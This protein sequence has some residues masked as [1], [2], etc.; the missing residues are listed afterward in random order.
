ML[1]LVLPVPMPQQ[2]QA[3]ASSRAHIEAG[4]ELAGATLLSWPA[5]AVAGAGATLLR[6]AKKHGRQQPQ[7]QPQPL[8]KL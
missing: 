8:R 4:A 3:G 7:Q 5:G 6:R 2:G 1:L